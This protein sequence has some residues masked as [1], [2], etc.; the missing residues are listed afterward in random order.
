MPRRYSTIII[1]A[2]VVVIDF[3]AWPLSFDVWYYC[4][5]TIPRDDM[6]KVYP[7]PWYPYVSTS[8]DFD[9]H[10]MC[11]CMYVQI[12]YIRYDQRWRFSRIFKACSQA[13]S[14]CQEVH[15]W[16]ET[17]DKRSVGALKDSRP[18]SFGKVGMQAC[19]LLSAPKT[20][21]HSELIIHN[22]R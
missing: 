2:E 16:N 9:D 8:P 11:A 4:A 12:M 19:S 20:L 10:N 13:S 21:T 3:T 1:S 17:M 7:S 22:P 15:N 14:S 18:S 5:V 6:N